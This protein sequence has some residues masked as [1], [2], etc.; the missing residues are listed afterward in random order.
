MGW[1]RGKQLEISPPL[2]WI[3]SRF[4]A[5]RQSVERGSLFGRPAGASERSAGPAWNQPSAPRADP[6]RP[7]TIPDTF[8]LWKSLGDRRSKVAEIPGKLRPPHANWRSQPEVVVQSR[9]EIAHD[10]HGVFATG[11]NFYCCY[12]SAGH[13]TSPE[14]P[15]PISM[16]RCFAGCHT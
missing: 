16:R 1:A 4:R 11:P 9:K 15:P 7:K 10:R 12:F 13:S 5:V 6:K 8:S 14:S 3:P 2:D